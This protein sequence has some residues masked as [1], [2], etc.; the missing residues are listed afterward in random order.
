MSQAPDFLGAIIAGGRSRRFTEN[1]SQHNDKFLNSFGGTTLLGHIISRAQAQISPLI[2]NVNGELARVRPY[3]LTV[4]CD[5][6]AGRGPLGGLLA[7]MK[8]AQVRGHSHI[9]TFSGDC[10]FFPEDY[11]ARMT[12][13]SDASIMIAR[14]DGKDHP[15]MGRFAASLSNDL[16]AYLE[17]GERRVM[18]WIK[19][20]DY[21]KVVWDDKNPDPF[22]NINSPSDLAAAEKYL[23]RLI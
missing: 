15:V 10:P 4:I 14:S 3:G 19:R 9:I 21:N 17:N 22:F 23:K 20:H 12:A 18:Q 11:A 16:A 2:L 5:D 8:E 13:D 1:S 7:V 6:I